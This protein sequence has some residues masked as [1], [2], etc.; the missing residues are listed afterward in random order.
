[1]LEEKNFANMN[2]TA[3]QSEEAQ[4]QA[5]RHHRHHHALKS[6]LNKR[7][8]QFSKVVTIDNLQQA[9]LPI[10]AGIK[11]NYCGKQHCDQPNHPACQQQQK[12]CEEEQ[13]LNQ[14]KQ[15]QYQEQINRQQQQL[16]QQFLQE[17]PAAA[18][19]AAA[20]R[21]NSQ[22]FCKSTTPDFSLKT[23]Q[24]N[25]TQSQSRSQ[26]YTI[27]TGSTSFECTGAIRKA[28]FLSVKKWLLR[29]RQHVELARKRG[30]KCYWCCLKGT[31]LLFYQCNFIDNLSLDKS[32]AVQLNPKIMQ[33]IA[34]GGRASSFALNVDQLRPYSSKS[35][36][37]L[38]D[39]EEN[40]Y[41]NLAVCSSCVHCSR[42]NRVISDESNAIYQNSLEANGSL[43]LC[44][45]C[46]QGQPFPPADS[47]GKCLCECHQRN[48]TTK[49]PHN[50]VQQIAYQP[51][52]LI[53]IDNSIVQPIPEHPKRYNVFCLS[54]A[55]GRFALIDEERLFI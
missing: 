26:Q 7:Q 40:L 55:I 39:F 25:S 41:E 34:S 48:G 43:V 20:S 44:L 49:K 19:A 29:K 38:G 14:L 18:A 32:G 3:D 52:H 46:S 17:N 8:P 6:N 33:Q 54:T 2:L 1:M 12:L 42:C 53:L 37:T 45:L 10:Q 50:F 24:F 23:D 28:G 16:N 27:Q 22:A 11:C 31:T 47:T 36:D 35:N 51:K 21:P 5:A 4:K 15:Q 9:Q 13:R 30:W